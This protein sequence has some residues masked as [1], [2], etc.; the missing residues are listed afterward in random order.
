MSGQPGRSGGARPGA[1][2]KPKSEKYAPQIAR[3]DNC[4]AAALPQLIDMLLGIASGKAERVEETTQP[5]GLVMVDQTSEILD[6]H[7]CPTG[8]VARSKIRAFPNLPPDRMVLVSRRVI[9]AEPDRAA[10][11]YLIDRI[12]G[13]PAPEPAPDPEEMKLISLN[14]A[15]LYTL[16]STSPDFA[17]RVIEALHNI[18]TGYRDGPGALALPPAPQDQRRHPELP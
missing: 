12:L 3:T 7:G 11:T 15:I 5:A 1:G 6:E 10:I 9:R 17:R 2:R 16:N 18:L 13:K 14:Q 4:I 8:R